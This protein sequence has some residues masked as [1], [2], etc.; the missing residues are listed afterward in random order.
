MVVEENRYTNNM[1]NKC[2][3]DRGYKQIII[4]IRKFEENLLFFAVE[5]ITTTKWKAK[6]V[7]SYLYVKIISTIP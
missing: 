6:D 7:R 5:N 2:T 3:Q 4:I 1:A